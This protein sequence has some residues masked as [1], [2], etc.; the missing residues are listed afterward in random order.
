MPTKTVR[1]VFRF[2]VLARLWPYLVALFVYTLAVESVSQWMHPPDGKLTPGRPGELLLGS[3]LFGWFMHFR[4]RA[5]YERWYDARILWGQ[6]VNHSRNLAL[7]AARL[8]PD[9]PAGVDRLRGLLGQFAAELR[10]YLARPRTDPGL[11]H[12]LATAGRVYDQLCE[13]KANGKL[14]G[15]AYLSLDRHGQAL[16]DVSGAC[17]RIRATPLAAS[18]TS[19][20][21][22]G[23]TLYLLSLPWLTADDLGWYT[24]LL[25]LPVGYVLIALELIATDIENPFDGGADD[26][27]LD[28]VVA[29]IKKSV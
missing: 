26:L 21:R 2:P 24:V 8:V 4:A 11:H 27:P 14:D 5:S 22:K 7:K 16:M 12:P 28:A 15:F 17:E 23:L 13:W 18:Y 20:M 19:L 29:T 1:Q 10:L 3:L 25:V 6:L 9:D